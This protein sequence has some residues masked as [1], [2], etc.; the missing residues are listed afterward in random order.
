VKISNFS[1][2]FI[3]TTCRRVL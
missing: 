1:S 3:S 2:N